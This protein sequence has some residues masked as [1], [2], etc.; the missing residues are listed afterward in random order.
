MGS[1]P[2]SQK[3]EARGQGREG[4]VSAKPSLQP[5]SDKPADAQRGFECKYFYLPSIFSAIF[6]KAQTQLTPFPLCQRRRLA[7][8]LTPAALP[9]W[10]VAGR[11]HPS[12]GPW[13]T[14]R[15]CWVQSRHLI[16]WAGPWLLGN[17]EGW[18]RTAL[19]SLQGLPETCSPPSLPLQ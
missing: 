8:S 14:N 16:R 3:P 10:Q 7:G 15:L 11:I 17:V 1:C 6:S 9:P 19:R 4:E 18:P 5:A 2:V 13:V 12:W